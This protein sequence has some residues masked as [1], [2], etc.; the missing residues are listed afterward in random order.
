M[1]FVKLAF[2][3]LGLWVVWA[4][5]RSVGWETIVSHAAA[6]HEK[7]FWLFL[8]YPFAYC[9]H[10]AGWADAFPRN[11]KRHIPFGDFVVVRLIGETLNNVVPWTASLGGEPV[12]AELLKKR[13][14]I[15]LSESYAAS[16]IVHTTLWISLNLFVIAALLAGFQSAPLSTELWQAL[17]V[18]LGVLA[19]LAVILGAGLYL[20][21][22]GTL[23]KIGDRFGWWGKESAEKKR[24]YD[25]LDGQIK[26]YYLAQRGRFTASA[27]MNLLGWMTG[28]VETYFL[29]RW[30]GLPVGFGE[31][32]LVEALIQALR[33]VTFFIPASLGAQEGGVLFLF[34]EFGF[35][36]P[37]AMTFAI[38]KRLR[39]LVW[40]SIGLLF[41]ASEQ[42]R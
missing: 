17:F 29:M 6:L 11:V 37:V 24:R 14:G 34:S 25:H 13:H 8:I 38:V 12:K 7:L 15:P 31:A 23:H 32:W 9:F 2:L 5:V 35:G 1:R 16:L 28:A 40:I 42:R 19:A 36:H 4:A 39:E 3:A 10:A 18:F 27:A 20:G 22:F 26:N 30:L 21:I 33:I 41:F